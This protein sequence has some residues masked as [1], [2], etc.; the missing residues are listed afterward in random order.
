MYDHN[1]DANT[2][3]ARE[4]PVNVVR[5]KGFAEADYAMAHAKD[6]FKRL[7][8]YAAVRDHG[9]KWGRKAGAT[10]DHALIYARDLFKRLRIHP[11]DDRPD[12]G[13]RVTKF[14]R[15]ARTEADHAMAYAKDLFKRLKSIPATAGSSGKSPFPAANAIGRAMARLARRVRGSVL[16]P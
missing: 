13:H 12:H 14:G 4:G 8:G 15:M 7:K 2:F 16:E 6:L 10:A 5:P 9:A 1:T 11:A 3:D